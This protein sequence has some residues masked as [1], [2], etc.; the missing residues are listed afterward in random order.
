[1]EM[2]T[3]GQWYL[4]MNKRFEKMAELLLIMQQVCRDGKRLS[5]GESGSQV[6]ASTID[7]N[8]ENSGNSNQNKPGGSANMDN[9]YDSVGSRTRSRKNSINEP[10][11]SSNVS[12]NT[13]N[14]NQNKTGGSAAQRSKQANKQ[15]PRKAQH[16]NNWSNHKKCWTDLPAGR[17]PEKCMDCH[18]NCGVQYVNYRR[19]YEGDAE[20]SECL[21]AWRV[22]SCDTIVVCLE[23]EVMYT[24]VVRLEGEV[25]K[26]PYRVFQSRIHPV[27][28]ILVQ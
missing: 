20:K 26:R 25:K 9:N 11:V 28:G 8:I 27:G 10:S 7:S 22:K 2:G 21:F 4:E 13:G 19:N 18:R 17:C 1:M 14:F 6:T 5:Q 16:K 15:K 12:E 24:I 23:G 3:R